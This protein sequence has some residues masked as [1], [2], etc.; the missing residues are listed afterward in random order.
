MRTKLAFLA[1][2]AGMLALTA[3]A[4]TV[5]TS[6]GSYD[7]RSSLSLNAVPKPSSTTLE[8]PSFGPKPRA[9]L[10]PKSYPGSLIYVAAGSQVKIFPERGFNPAQIGQLP[11]T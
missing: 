1:M 2:G 8:R 10:R 3:C 11:T 6:I 5:S 7:A 9:W 4:S